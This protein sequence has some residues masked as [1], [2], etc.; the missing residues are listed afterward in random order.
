MFSCPPHSPNPN[1]V[2][3]ILSEEFSKCYPLIGRL[4]EAAVLWLGIDLYSRFLWWEDEFI[5]S[6][7]AV[8]DFKY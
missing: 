7:L 8:V 3:S 2:E 5:I 6:D 4:C 1:V